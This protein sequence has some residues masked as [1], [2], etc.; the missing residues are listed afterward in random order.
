MSFELKALSFFQSWS[1]ILPRAGKHQSTHSNT[2]EFRD[3][4]EACDFDLVVEKR[5]GELKEGEG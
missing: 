3:E 2:E 4:L 5:G 1:C